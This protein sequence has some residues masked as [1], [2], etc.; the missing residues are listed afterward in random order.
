MSSKQSFIGSKIELS[1]RRPPQALA[2]CLQLTILPNL[3]HAH[4][5]NTDNNEY[6]D[7]WGVGWRSVKYTTPFEDRKRDQTAGRET[8]QGQWISPSFREFENFAILDLLSAGR[9]EMIVGR[10]AFFESFPLFGYDVRDYD[11]LFSEK[12]ELLLKLNSSERVTWQ[13]IL[14]SPLEN[15]QIAP[16]SKWLVQ[17]NRA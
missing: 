1:D 5:G 2:F 16:L 12:L 11:Q 7:E 6:P 15:V 4:I 8:A 14:C 17:I 10:G 9:A 3:C 13:G